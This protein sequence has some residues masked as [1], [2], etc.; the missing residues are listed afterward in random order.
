MINPGSRNGDSAAAEAVQHL[1][2]LG[3]LHVFQVDETDAARQAI[4]EHGGPQTRVVLGGGDGTLTC[5]VDAVLETASTLGVLPM[6]TAN[7]FARSL[8][9]PDNIPDAA[10]IITADNVRRVDVGRVNGKAFLNAVGIGV[11]PKV[12]RELDADA[13][14]HLGVLAY[15]VSLASAIR[16]SRP[17]R[18]QIDVDGETHEAR[19][20]QVTIG[21]GIHYGGG[22]TIHEDARLDDGQL[23][24]I[25]VRQQSSW[26]LARRFLALRWGEL[27]NDPDLLVLR[28][29]GVR[30]TTR[31]SM[32]ASADGELSSETPLDCVCRRKELRVLAPLVEEHGGAV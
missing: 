16:R 7:D 24:V 1:Q 27:S 14:Q 12:T 2:P 23:T 28:G 30:V 21:N 18:V 13:K 6:G 22:M 3:P 4:L 26:R 17:F 31:K 25:C 8:G 9:L 32:P 15:P 29:R 5:L 11:G 19:C 20:I 10:A